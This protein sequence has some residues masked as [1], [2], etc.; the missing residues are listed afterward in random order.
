[1]ISYQFFSA[2]FFVK[3]IDNNNE[4][5]N[6]NIFILAKTKFFFIM[7]FFINNLL[8]NKNYFFLNDI[9]FINNYLNLSILFDNFKIFLICSL[10]L[11]IF[12]FISLNNMI[13]VSLLVLRRKIWI[14]FLFFTILLNLIFT[15]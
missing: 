7:C 2:F 14:K 11:H 9:F 6:K 1:M 12:S 10:F 4:I 8:L 13:S 15:F 5:R 3:L